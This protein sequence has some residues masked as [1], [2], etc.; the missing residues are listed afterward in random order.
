MENK[1]KEWIERE[2][3]QA[4]DWGVNKYSVQCATH[5]SFGVLFRNQ[6]PIRATGVMT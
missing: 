1:V 6:T 3:K 2:Y 4:K 5:R